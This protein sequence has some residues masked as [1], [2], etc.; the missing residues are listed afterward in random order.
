M[1]LYVW[2]CK[3]CGTRYTE[4]FSRVRNP[5]IGMEVMIPCPYACKVRPGITNESVMVLREI[6]EVRR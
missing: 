3:C 4:G 6:R 2:V 1:K 5:Y